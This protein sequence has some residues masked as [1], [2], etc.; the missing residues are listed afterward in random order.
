MREFKGVYRG[1]TPTD[2]SDIML[3]EIEISITDELIKF[4]IATGLEI[5]EEEFR[6]EDFRSL[7]EE[8]TNAL[9]LDGT[10]DEIK[11][12]VTVFKCS[13][14]YPKFLFCKDL[15]TNEVSLAVKMGMGD[16][17]GPTVLL[18]P[19]LV[20]RGEFEKAVQVI[21]QGGGKGVLPRLRN[22]GK[23]ERNK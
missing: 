23:A 9:C 7:T 11:S 13:S 8:E 5:M 12:N 19:Q 6:V 21:E 1:F 20:M 4:R 14:E 3:G 15:E 18:G 10:P 17:L 22:N 16:I 2:E